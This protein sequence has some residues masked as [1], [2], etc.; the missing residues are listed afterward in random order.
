MA[1]GFTAFG[2]E[3]SDRVADWRL[4]LETL[5]REG[6]EYTHWGLDEDEGGPGL[7]RVRLAP[8]EIYEN[9]RS[10]VGWDEYLAGGFSAVSDRALAARAEASSLARPDVEGA[11]PADFI[12]AE[13]ETVLCGGAPHRGERLHSHVQPDDAV[14]MIHEVAT[15]LPTAAK[16][17]TERGV[18]RPS[19]AI[20]QERD[21]QDL[22]LVILRSL[23]HDTRREE[24][25]PSS[26]G[27]S[28]RMD[29]AIP[30]ARIVIEVKVVRDAAHGR[31]IGDELKIDIE[32]YHR[33]AACGT[34]FALVWDPQRFLGDAHQLERDLTGSRTKSETTFD[35][36]VRVL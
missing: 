30:S 19:F 11:C 2:H 6:I 25:T 9:V 31:R 32:S 16:A 7:Y 24:W 12:S 28:K 21:L 27:S 29:I 34:L 36:A 8:A 23:F 33:H 3:F 4:E 22:L 10:I 5:E 17:L 13:L 14:A 20:E 1:G 18:K 15:G 26:A 35:V